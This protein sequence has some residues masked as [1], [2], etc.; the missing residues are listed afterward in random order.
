MNSEQWTMGSDIKELSERV[1]MG[2]VA[3]PFGNLRAG[4]ESIAAD[5]KNIAAQVFRDID[6]LLL[7]TTTATIPTRKDAAANPSPPT[8]HHSRITMGYRLSASRAALTATAC[9]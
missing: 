7:P 6:I 8:I 4:I 2:N 1:S 5:R 9:L 3:I